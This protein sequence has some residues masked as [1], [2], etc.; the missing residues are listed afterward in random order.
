MSR[1]RS[2]PFALIVHTSSWLS[3]AIR[4]ERCVRPEGS[5]VGA[6]RV[7]VEL[8]AERAPLGAE[9]PE[10]ATRSISTAVAK[11]LRRAFTSCFTRRSTNRFPTSPRLDPRVCEDA[12][13][14]KGKT[15]ANKDKGGAKNKKVASK[16]LKEKREAK[17]A[18][19]AAGSRG[20]DSS[21]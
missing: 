14:R 19:G 11:S 17:K 4:P 16:T 3:N 1:V 8:G 20:S 2:V 6:E 15:M 5:T 18:K 21:R 7:A 13:P 10:Q 12:G 9:P